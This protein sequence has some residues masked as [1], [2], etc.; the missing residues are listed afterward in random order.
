MEHWRFKNIMPHLAELVD[1][2]L[3]EVQNWLL[4]PLPIGLDQTRERM[5]NRLTGHLC[6]MIDR[7]YGFGRPIS[8]VC[9]AMELYINYCIK[10]M[11]TIVECVLTLVKRPSSEEAEEFPFSDRN[12]KSM[13]GIC[14]L[15]DQQEM[16]DEVCHH[17]HEMISSN[18]PNHLY[19]SRDYAIVILGLAEGTKKHDLI[20][21]WQS[22][23][24]QRKHSIESDK[25][26]SHILE[27]DAEGFNH[28]LA[29]ILL[30]KLG[31]ER[32]RTRKRN[33][34]PSDRFSLGFLEIAALALH[35][36]IPLTF[37]DEAIPIHEF[38]IAQRP[39]I[40]ALLPE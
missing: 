24:A 22:F 8:D 5:N 3:S 21:Y 32:T 29:R 23:I 38:P 37:K 28:L 14:L 18:W 35:N 36:G 15:I 20:N 13:M 25:L 1:S 40:Q 12:F 39:E 34:A 30:D 31:S 27:E 6:F 17:L 11:K 9:G 4:S 33:I 2:D 7:R 26:I 10:N 19:Y 16:L